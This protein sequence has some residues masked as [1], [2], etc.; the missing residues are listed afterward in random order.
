VGQVYVQSISVNGGTAATP[1][2]T[3]K[4]DLTVSGG[5]GSGTV[6]S[7]VEGDSITVDATDPANPVVGV[8]PGSFDTAAARD[9]AIAAQHTTDVG[10]FA[11]A[12]QG[13]LADSAVQPG[14]LGTAATHAATDFA[15]AAQGALADTADQAGFTA[16]DKTRLADTSGTNTGDQDLSGL[17]TTSALTTEASTARAAESANA[18]AITN[19]AATARAAEALKL[20]KASNLSDLAN[21]GTARGNLGLGTAA[22]VDTGTGA[23]NVVL[24][25][26]SRLSDARTPTA[27]AS[28]HEAGGTDEIAL[29]VSQITATGTPD[30]TTF[31]RGDGMWDTPSGGGGIPAPGS[32]GQILTA[33]S[34]QSG[35]TKWAPSGPRPIGLD[36]ASAT[37]NNSLS[38]NSPKFCRVISGAGLVSSIGLRV[39]TS[40][41]NIGVAVF[42]DNGSDAPG[43]LV[44][45]SASVACPASG[46]A[47]VSLGSTVY[48]GPGDWL[49]LTA[50]NLTAT[51]GAAQVTSGPSWRNQKLTSGS[52]APGAFASNPPTSDDTRIFG[53]WGV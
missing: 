39:Q 24:G 30:N 11:T 34:S 51:F 17:A 27:H 25:N 3:G 7:I 43:A 15:T 14:D 28:T 13:A 4:V 2:T 36:P 19:E 26:D 53:L 9:A 32:D 5:G 45:Q 12:A 10:L 18:T 52:V 23:A 40:S 20:A 6:D 37:A 47:A 8:T 21:A 44:A 31:L 1:D 16:A 48:V 50:D 22:V 35:G 46:Q 49:A 33:D 29:D 38:P 41:G 42:R